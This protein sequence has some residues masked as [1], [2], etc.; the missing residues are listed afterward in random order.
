[1]QIPKPFLTILGGIQPDMIEEI[2]K[3]ETA[4][5]ANDGFIDRFL[6]CYPDP[7]PSNWTDEDVSEEV[8]DE[9]C[10]VVFKLY[11][12]LPENDPKHCRAMNRL[13]GRNRPMQKMHLLCGMTLRKMKLWQLDFRMY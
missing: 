9:Y 5:S 12:S 4:G 8:V 10:S 6:F 3:A 11:N 1:M 7:V 13:K 2:V